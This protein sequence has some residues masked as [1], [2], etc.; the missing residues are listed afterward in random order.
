VGQAAA[1]VR[2]SGA[3]R[4]GRDRLVQLAPFRQSVDHRLPAQE[5]FS[6][7]FFQ[8]LYGLTLSPGKGLLWYTPLFFASLA[9]WPAFFRRHRIEAL[10]AAAVVVVNILFYAPWYLWWGGHS[11]GPR[12]LVTVLPFAALPLVEALAAAKC[13]RLVAVGVAALAAASVCRPV[14][15]C[16]RQL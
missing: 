16:G 4:T 13:H 3:C 12:F 2:T 14:P 1:T 5:A 10:L 8:G 11:W 7:P 15:G 9:A 6:A